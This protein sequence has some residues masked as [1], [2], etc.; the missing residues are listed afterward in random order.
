MRVAFRVDASLTIGTGHVMRCLT[1][2]DALANEEGAS[3]L[4]IMRESEG[5]LESCIRDKGYEVYTL[6]PIQGEFIRCS[7]VETELPPHADWLVGGWELDACET[8]K[9]LES[10]CCDWL[11]IDHYGID[12]QWEKRVSSLVKRILVIDDLADRSHL[13]DVVLDQN[14][15]RTESDYSELVPEYC[16]KLMGPMYALLRPEFSEH[17]LNSLQRRQSGCSKSILIAMGGVDKDD[18]TSTLLAILD[19]MPSLKECS[20]QVVLGASAPWAGNV[21][22]VA[23]GLKASTEVLVGV[24]NMAELMANADLAIGAAGGTA[25]E[26]C[27]LGL[28]TLMLTLAENQVPG[29]KAMDAE[30]AAIWLGYPDEAMKAL[31]AVLGN[32]LRPENLIRHS[33]AASSLCDGEGVSRVMNILMNS[34]WIDG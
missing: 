18:L 15:G 11:I 33:E 14:I 16:V 30:S 34:E 7:V 2:A 29:A 12:M 31:P 25:L 9:V 17:R 20:I 6:P 19:S 4:F 21:K 28:P 5:G 1:L 23:A 3:C 8:L 26:R 24:S 22:K 13:C 27:C 32:F 10:I